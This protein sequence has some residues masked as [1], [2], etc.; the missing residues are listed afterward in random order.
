LFFIYIND[1]E[2]SIEAGRLTTFADDTSILISGNN[3]RDVQI[4][5]NKTINAL[6]KWCERNSLIINKEKISFHQHQKTQVE[7][8]LINYN[9]KEHANFLGVWLDKNLKWTVH[10]QQLANKL[11]KICFALLVIKRVAG[12]ETVRTLY[13]AY[14]HSLLLYGLVFWGNSGSEKVI[15]RMQ[16]RA[17]RA[18]VQ[19]PNNISCKQYFKALH[20]L[21]LP[22]LYIN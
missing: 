2:T 4:K 12:L 7:K 8:P 1:L 14:F 10:T 6:I 15:F 22:S 9:Y 19:I 11:G 3:A 16:K 5:I 18:T 17:I 13:Y 20:I 21:P